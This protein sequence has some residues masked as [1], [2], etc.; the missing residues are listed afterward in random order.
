MELIYSRRH[1]IQEITRR[2]RRRQ[3]ILGPFALIKTMLWDPI[4]V[5]DQRTMLAAYTIDVESQHDFFIVTVSRLCYYCGSSVQTFFLY[6]LHD[7]IR[8]T[9]DTESAVATLAVVS[10]ISGALFCYPMGFF[11]DRFCDGRRKPFVYTACV[12]LGAVTFSMVFART[13]NQMTILCF[14]LGAANGSYLTMETSLAVDT[15]P[16][17]YE[18]GPSGGHAQLLGIWGVAAF[19]GSA[20]GPM[21][22]GPLLY[23]VG[24]RGPLPEGQDYSIYGYAVVLL[25]STIYFLLSAISLRWVRKVGV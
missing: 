20:L 19:L 7:I 2:H 4:R 10:Q 3:L 24:S 18:D 6:F 1:T 25:L 23:L 14:I 16:D 13:M 11:S 9:D 12:F 5:L 21:V 22:G 8:V 15:L 17:D